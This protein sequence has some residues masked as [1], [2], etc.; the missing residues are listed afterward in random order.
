MKFNP[1]Q[2]L[3]VVAVIIVC[4]LIGLLSL[5]APKT[6]A[7]LSTPF[8]R[9]ADD[10][11]GTVA[12]FAVA[13]TKSTIVTNADAAPVDLTDSRVSHGRLRE[14]VAKVE[15]AAGDDDG[16]VFRMFRVWSGWRITSIE[17]ASDAIA[18]GTAYDVGVYQTAENGGAAVD[19]D[20]FASAL[21]LSS[22]S[23]FTDRT[24]E[25]GATEIDKIEQPLWERI[26]ETSD[27]KR[28]YDICLTGDTV[29]TGAGT[30]AARLRYVDGS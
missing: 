27:T 19:D 30:I 4:A 8:E 2:I 13:N 23:G 18:G 15:V 12:F 11:I 5:L 16:S 9:W 1:L 21:D 6:A 26:G 3:V 17:I 25:A 10:M 14:Q 28:W 22:A 29:G 24:Y 7:K 20:E